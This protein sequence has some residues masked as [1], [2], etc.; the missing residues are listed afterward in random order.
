[1]GDLNAL[2]MAWP[3]L[4]GT[5]AQKLATLNAMQVPGPS[6]D[7]TVATLQTFITSNGLEAPLAAYVAR[8]PNA[9]QPALIACNYLLAIL[10]ASDPIIHTSIPSNFATVEQLGQAL[11]TDPATGITPTLLTQM[12]ALIQPPALWWQVHG[13]AAAVSITDL[14]AAGN[15]Y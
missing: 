9:V 6:Q 5:T 7:I 8:G 3:S 1:M 12:I 10:A 11:L 2:R 15:L 13:F 4:T 14:I